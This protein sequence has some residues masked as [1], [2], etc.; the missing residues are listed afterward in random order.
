MTTLLNSY[1][2]EIQITYRNKVSPSEMPQINTSSEA[3]RLM[4]DVDHMRESLEYKECFYSIFLNRSNKV[5][6]VQL[7]SDGGMTGTVAD[8]K[9]IFQAALK[10]HAC[11]IIVVHNHPS[12][13]P[14]PSEADKK[15]THRLISAGEFL[16]IK[17]IDHIIITAENYFSFADEGLIK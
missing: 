13:N 11:S 15:L 14:K 16:D 8:P 17:V 3:F 10:S 4:S 5:L 1:I 2:A 12:G 6:G 9:I 7:V